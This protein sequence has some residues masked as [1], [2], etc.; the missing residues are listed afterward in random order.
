[1]NERITIDQTLVRMLS[2][3]EEAFKAFS[4][5]SMFASKEEHWAV[6]TR[7]ND[8]CQKLAAYVSIQCQKAMSGTLEDD[9][10]DDTAGY[11]ASYDAGYSDGYDDGM[12]TAARGMIYMEP[13]S[14]DESAGV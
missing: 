10:D 14:S 11:D 6:T 4:A 12:R 7:L 13:E 1:M 2:E 9:S 3:Y 8:A 5:L